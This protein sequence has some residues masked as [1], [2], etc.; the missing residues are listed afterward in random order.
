MSNKNDKNKIEN[1]YNKYQEIIKDLPCD[2]E[3]KYKFNVIVR[4]AVLI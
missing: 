1:F 4:N 3:K 2:C